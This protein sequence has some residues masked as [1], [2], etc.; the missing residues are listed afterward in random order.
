MKQQQHRLSQ[1]NISLFQ[2]LLFRP[3]SPF[4]RAYTSGLCIAAVFFLILK[5]IIFHCKHKLELHQ[6]F[7]RH[8]KIFWV[9]FEKKALIGLGHL[10]GVRK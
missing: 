2:H 10:F 6:S 8:V 9:T 7:C 1:A 5:S 3:L 4:L